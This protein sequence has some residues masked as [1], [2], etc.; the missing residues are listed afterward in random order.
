MFSATE[1]IAQCHRALAG[2][3][4]D[5]AIKDL[6]A[7]AVADPVRVRQTMGY[8]RKAGLHVLFRSP[9]LTVLNVIWA[10]DMSIYPHDHRM[11][12][13]LGLY[14]GKEENHFY[15][16]MPGGLK[17]V[18]CK[19]LDRRDV[20][21]LGPEAIHSVRNPIAQFTAALHIYGGDFF[22]ASRSEFDPKTFVERPYDVE[23]AK[24]LFEEANGQA[25]KVPGDA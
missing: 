8:P 21:R 10:P 25:T 4:P 7:E 24:R 15:R 12:A 19:T 20:I 23:R 6:V 11:W 9:A 22:A 14:C 1:L 5:L 3:D 18:S 13:V 17:E 2:P 16:R